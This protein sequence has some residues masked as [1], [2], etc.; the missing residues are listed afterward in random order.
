[1]E[2]IEC[3]SKESISIK[4]LAETVL[5]DVELDVKPDI[6]LDIELEVE[7]SA[8][9]NKFKV[10]VSTNMRMMNHSKTNMSMTWI[11]L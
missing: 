8:K 1:M 4:A 11:R 9:F 10:I 6:G 3:D 5:E 7:F 2:V